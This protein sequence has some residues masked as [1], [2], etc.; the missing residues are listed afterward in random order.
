M[1][2]PMQKDIAAY[3]IILKK[4]KEPE[5]DHRKI[6][7]TEDSDKLHYRDAISKIQSMGNFRAG[8][9]NPQATDR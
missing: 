1:C 2:L 9:P 5:L 7:R 4:K 3:E 6:Q 8:V